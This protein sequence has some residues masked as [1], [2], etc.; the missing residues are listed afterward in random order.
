MK[1]DGRV[2]VHRESK[3]RKGKGVSIIRGLPLTGPDLKGLA[4]ELKQACGCGGTVRDGTIEIQGDL[5]DKLVDELIKR[6]YEAKKA[7]G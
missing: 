3:G 1:G 5:R 7:G 4:K 2:R 6:G